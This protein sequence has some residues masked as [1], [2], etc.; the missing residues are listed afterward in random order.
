MAEEKAGFLVLTRPRWCKQGDAA[1]IAPLWKLAGAGVSA[2]TD[3]RKL[4]ALRPGMKNI[5][6]SGRKT[7]LTLFHHPLPPLFL[8]AE[9]VPAGRRNGGP[10]PPQ[11]RYIGCGG[12]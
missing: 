3:A 1:L 7:D 10:A 12:S 2:G 4:S 9:L 6:V 8:A 11:G 5:R